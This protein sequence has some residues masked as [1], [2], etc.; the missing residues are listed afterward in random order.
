MSE[1][2]VPPFLT[3]TLDGA[4]W[5]AS[6]SGCFAPGETCSGSLLDRK[7]G[8]PRSGLDAVE[9]IKILHLLEIKPLPS[10]PWPVAIPT[11]LFRIPQYFYI[12]KYWSTDIIGG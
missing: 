10:S 6:C 12:T 3:A 4:E 8:G 5:S 2:T 11:V 9:K 1:G 7:L